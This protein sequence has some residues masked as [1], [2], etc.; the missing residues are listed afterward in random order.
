MTSAC[1][2]AAGGWSV[3]LLPFAAEESVA[4]LQKNLQVCSRA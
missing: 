4:Q 3:Q 2:T 1:V